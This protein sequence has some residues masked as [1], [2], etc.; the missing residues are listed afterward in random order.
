MPMVKGKLAFEGPRTP[1]RGFT[2]RATYLEEPKGDALIEIFRDGKP[3]REFM[4]RELKG[5]SG[6][7]Q[8]KRKG[9][10]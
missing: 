7:R 10:R 9:A 6:A 4:V 5:F 1:D 3:H 8:T 2:I